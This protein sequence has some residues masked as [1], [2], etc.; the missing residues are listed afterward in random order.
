MAEERSVFDPPKER[1]IVKDV[2]TGAA[3][4]FASTMLGLGTASVDGMTMMKKM[5]VEGKSISQ[6][7]QEATATHETFKGLNQMTGLP[8]TREQAAQQ[9]LP[10]AMAFEGG[11]A[12]A[13]TRGPTL[14]R[15]LARTAGNTGMNI[16]IE[17][18][19]DLAGEGTAMAL[20]LVPGFGTRTAREA[21]A[22]QY[23]AKLTP[24]QIERIKNGTITLA[25]ITNDPALMATQRR[26]QADPKTAGR[27][28]DFDRQA[29][30]SIESRLEA[31]TARPS[32]QT[33]TDM[34]AGPATPPTLVSSVYKAY[35]K[36]TDSLKRAKEAMSKRDF[37]RVK[38]NIDPDAPIVNSETIVQKL[39]EEIAAHEKLKQTDEVKSTITGLKKLR[40]EFFEQTGITPNE[41][42]IEKMA[43]LE[44]K[45][46]ILMDD[47]AKA[48]D[49]KKRNSILLQLNNID[50]QIPKLQETGE[51]ILKRKDLS[52]NE[53]QAQ[54]SQ[55]SGKM[56]SGDG[57]FE[58]VSPEAAKRIA[59]NVFNAYGDAIEA[60]K[61]GTTDGNIAD[62]LTALQTARKNYKTSLDRIDAFQ[63]RE[64]S[65]YFGSP[66]NVSALTSKPDAVMEK[67]ASLSPNERQ[68]AF[69]II[70]KQLPDGEAVIQGLRANQWEKMLESARV[71]GGSD[72]RVR[73]DVNKFLGEMDKADERLLLDMIPDP[74]QRKQVRD[75]LSEMRIMARRNDWSM[76]E[77]GTKP[78]TEAIG[79]VAQA[80]GARTIV[81]SG[82]LNIMN[83]IKNGIIGPD[84]LLN[85]ML[86][87]EFKGNTVGERL[88]NFTKSVTNVAI[89]SV[90]DF[91]RA[92]RPAID[93]LSKEQEVAPPAP[94]AEELPPPPPEGFFPPQEEL[95]PPP[96]A[97]FFSENTPTP[98]AGNSEQQSMRVQPSTQVMRDDIRRQ[99]LEEELRTETNPEARASIQRELSR[100]K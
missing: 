97:G 43:L 55:W 67:I 48:T 16:G 28:Q 100:I 33:G 64:L 78:G 53:I 44:D 37:D 20:A 89:P 23:A 91:T 90:T 34:S 6:A 83:D 63:N 22:A 81:A 35:E 95:P 42:T 4:G 52:V 30:T 60:T 36:Q 40:N 11:A 39:D 62:A 24:D 65:K 61:K 21:L 54:L 75:T 94:T 58:G 41:N 5:F 14:G 9:S 84:R 15:V 69:E 50:K 72:T 38:K 76:T 71:K 25:E 74:V 18:V 7:L 45:R 73:F 82:L 92:M 99:I 19:G 13:P 68:V 56:F 96:P 46:N 93:E 32:I 10:T 1:S 29:A 51:P 2:F 26:L 12:L 31:A 66:D 59:R 88:N 8:F 57:L 79:A 27:F 85:M 3:G 77:K 98:K 49:P 86:H 17:G 70:R 87:P 47:L 80:T